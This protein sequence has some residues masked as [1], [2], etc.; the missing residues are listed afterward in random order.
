MTHRQTWRESP[1]VALLWQFEF[2]I[3]DFFL[4]CPLANHFICLVPSPYL[5][6]LGSFP[7]VCMHLLINWFYHKGL[8]V[9]HP[10][11]HSPSISIESSVHVWSGGLYFENQKYKLSEQSPMPSI[12]ILFL[13]FQPTGNEAPISLSWHSPS[14][15]W[16]HFEN[17]TSLSLVISG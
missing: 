17:I 14:I 7:C 11:H 13:E 4:E 9:E 10:Q 3:G 16:P 2:L 12:A 6:S 15:S 8:W 5:I 1:W